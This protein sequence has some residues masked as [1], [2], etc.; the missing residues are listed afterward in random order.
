PPNVPIPAGSTSGTFAVT[1]IAVGQTAITATLGGVSLPAV[2][3]TVAVP[4]LTN[5]QVPIAI[6]SGDTSTGTVTLSGAAP[7]GGV[8][9]SLTS[10]NPAVA[11]VPTSVQVSAGSATGT[12]DVTGNVIGQAT[13]TASSGGVSRTA[14]V[15]VQ[16]DPTGEKL[17]PIEK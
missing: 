6:I 16:K 9:V 2:T 17:A 3:L 4:V 1:G 14:I 8:L 13:I 5:L 7:A 12:F 11:A 15:R 10:S